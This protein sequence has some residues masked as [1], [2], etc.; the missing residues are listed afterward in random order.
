MEGTR[1]AE[2]KDIILSID[3][4][5]LPGEGYAWRLRTADGEIISE[6]PALPSLNACLH[7]A[8]T[9]SVLSSSSGGPDLSGHLKG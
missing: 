7:D 4:F 9:S 3:I 1:G 6:S 8:C 2:A 5:E